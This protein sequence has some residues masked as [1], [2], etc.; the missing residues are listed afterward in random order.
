MKLTRRELAA[1]AV[2]PALA[3]QSPSPERAA[4]D[5]ELEAARDTVRRN[6]ETLARRAVPMETEPAFQFK[7]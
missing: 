4:A 3:A 6:G 7:P 2:A 5:K 1:A